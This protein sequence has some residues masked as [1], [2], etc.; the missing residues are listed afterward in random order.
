MRKRY[1]ELVMTVVLILAALALSKN[2]VHIASN[3]NTETKK[4][5]VVVD[6]GHG[7]NDPGKVGVNGVKEKDLNLAIAKELQK[8]LSKNGILVIMT[9]EEDMGLYNPNSTNKKVEDMRNRCSLIADSHAD[10]TISIHQNSYHQ[11]SVKGLQIFYYEHSNEGKKIAEH[12]Q[13]RLINELD[14]SNARKAKAN[15]SYYLLRKTETPTI[16]VECGFLS[17]AEE[18]E[19][20]ATEEYQKKIAKVLAEGILDYFK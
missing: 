5:I 10:L 16:I 9:R 19:K 13:D 8:V 14:K 12:L 3:S 11:N 2:A 15:D 7:G 1:I 20:L 17:N 18:A 6:A 4:H